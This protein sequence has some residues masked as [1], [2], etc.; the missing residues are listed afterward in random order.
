M[1][2]ID[3]TLPRSCS[4]CR[5]EGAYNRRLGYECYALLDYVRAEGHC[6]TRDPECPLTEI[7]NGRHLCKDCAH[8]IPYIEVGFLGDCALV[9]KRFE[10]A[11]TPGRDPG[12]RE[13]KKRT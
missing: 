6:L 11:E 4:S 5:F 12:C 13:W 7:D 1:I 8:Y 9:D 10:T 3:M 2:Q